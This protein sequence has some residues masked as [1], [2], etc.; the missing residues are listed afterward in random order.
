MIDV[1]KTPAPFR[2]SSDEEKA[3]AAAFESS[4][5]RSPSPSMK[6]GS[7]ESDDAAE[8]GSTGA[9]DEIDVDTDKLETRATGHMGKSSSV[10]WAKRVA[11][12]VHQSGNS[13]PSLVSDGG[14]VTTTY[15]TEDKDVDHIEPEDVDLFDWPDTET[16]D[17]YVKSYFEHVHYALPILD[18]ADFMLEY[19]HFERGSRDLTSSQTVWL[20][21]VNAVFA[22]GSQYAQITET[23]DRELHFEHYIYC[24]RA[25]GLL[26][27]EGFL[28]QD[29]SI[30]TLRALGLLS[31]YYMSTVRL[32]RYVQLFFTRTIWLTKSRAWTLCGLAVRHALTLGLHVRNEA[33]ELS[34]LGKEQ[35]VRLWWCLY[36]MECSLNELTGRPS[37]ISDQDI[38]TPLPANIAVDEIEAGQSLYGHEKVREQTKRHGPDDNKDLQG[39]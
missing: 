39:R 11:N 22:I 31:L 21:T 2:T 38:S 20:G 7:E 28:Y 29:I 1:R 32:N 12:E 14:F 33:K 19:A 10:T 4:D 8:V 6:R 18:K 36:S 3:V 24:A 37:C 30:R 25:K 35:R 16:A 23:Q 17:S 15:H 27:D 5:R 9:L 26:V 13:I 34:D